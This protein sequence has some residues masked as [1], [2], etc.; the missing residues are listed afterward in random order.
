[1]GDGRASRGCPY[2]TLRH[3]TTV[4]CEIKFMEASR[5]V[6]II[7]KNEIRPNGMIG[8]EETI[9]SNDRYD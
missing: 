8:L 6:G 9:G 4:S 5:I 2:P 3:R 7:E 1:M